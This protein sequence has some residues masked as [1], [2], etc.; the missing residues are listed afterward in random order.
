MAAARAPPGREGPRAL[1]VPVVGKRSLGCFPGQQLLH[2][3]V[4]PE[5]EPAGD[6]FELALVLGQEE[7]V[8]RGGSCS[9]C[10]CRSACC[11]V[12]DQEFTV[13]S[14]LFYFFFFHPEG[15]IN[16]ISFWGSEAAAACPVLSTRERGQSHGSPKGVLSCFGNTDGSIILSSCVSRRLIPPATQK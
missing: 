2:C 8:S 1:P 3:S 7:P 9:V 13:S 4:S 5:R 14:I 10:C 16:N 11:C 6:L 12:P 15:I